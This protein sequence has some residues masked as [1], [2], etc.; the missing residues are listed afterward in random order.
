MLYYQKSLDLNTNQL[1]KSKEKER[2]NE[3]N[4]EINRKKDSYG[5]LSTS[6]RDDSVVGEDGDER[7]V[8]PLAAFVIVGIVSWET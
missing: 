7:Q 6:V 8:V 3:I 2:V 4:R 5:E 1:I